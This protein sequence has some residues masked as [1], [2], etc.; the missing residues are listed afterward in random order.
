MN[1]IRIF[2]NY[3]FYLGLILYNDNRLIISRL[4]KT[5]NQIKKQFITF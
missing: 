2:I 5:K 3:F 1:K 4:K